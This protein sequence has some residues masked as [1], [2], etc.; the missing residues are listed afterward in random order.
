M[1]ID[2]S[3]KKTFL[4]LLLFSFIS[5]FLSGCGYKPTYQL[6]PLKQKVTYD[7]ITKKT[8]K[9]DV[10]VR[11]RICSREYVR[12]VLG[13][14]ADALMSLRSNKRIIPV[15]IYIENSSDY[16]WSLSPYDIHVPLVNVEVVKS[17]FF[18]CATQKGLAS[19][20]A[21][22][23]LGLLCICFGTGAS[24]LHPVA[25]ASIFGIGCSLLLTGPMISHNVSANAG[26]Q[27]ACYEHV[28]DSL[29][30]TNDIIIHPQEHMSKLLF[31]EKKN[32]PELLHIR[33]CDVRN[34]D[35]TIFYQL[36]IDTPSNKKSYMR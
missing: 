32:M 29:T 6:A 7:Q 24:L 21:Y 36:Y 9:G 26:K 8:D 10:T 18:K 23:A 27:N 14:Q 12:E 33:L 35:H 16:I 15:Q 31:I 17:R 20:G 3:Y 1:S 30:L 5:L 19:L 13:K 4:L 2:F 28:L 34:E 25:G 22:T 11:C